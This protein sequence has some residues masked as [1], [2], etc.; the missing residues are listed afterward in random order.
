M[1]IFHIVLTTFEPL[2]PLQEVQGVVDRLLALKDNCIHPVSKKP[3]IKTG[4]GG[5]DNSPEGLQNGITHAFVF[6][7]ENEQDREFYLKED[8]AHL[9]FVKSIAGVV[10][11]VQVIDFTPGLF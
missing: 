3:Y 2:A 10:S 11:K 5:K 9:E 6:E 7:F 1:A 8:P 4:L